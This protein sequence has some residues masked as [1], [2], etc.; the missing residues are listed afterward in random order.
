M[1]CKVTDIFHDNVVV[2]W[3][4]PADDGG[5]DITRYMWQFFSNFLALFLRPEDQS[6]SVSEKLFSLRYIILEL[7]LQF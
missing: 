7:S 4:P 2:N 5:T 3:T 6:Q 1:S